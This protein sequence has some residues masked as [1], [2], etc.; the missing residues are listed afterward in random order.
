MAGSSSEVRYAEIEHETAHARV[1]VVLDLDGGTRRDIATGIGSLDHLLSQWAFFA[2]FDLGLNCDGDLHLDDQHTVEAI[3]AALGTAF[4]LALA[5]SGP[6]ERMG[7]AHGISEEAM[8]LVATD[9][10]G[11]GACAFSVEFSRERLGLLATQSIREFFRAFARTAKIT[12]H[13][14]KMAGDNDHHVAEAI[15]RGFGQALSYATH[16]NEL[17]RLSKGGKGRVE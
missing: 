5:E 8:A 14:Q 6:I 15:F 3:G 17:H 11:H 12:L 13:I 2:G 4:C 7:S 9:V 16:R 10:V 1:Q